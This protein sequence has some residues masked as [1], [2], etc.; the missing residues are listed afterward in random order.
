M[1]ARIHLEN[2]SLWVS[3]GKEEI[4]PKKEFSFLQT[5]QIWFANN[6]DKKM[7]D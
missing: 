2:L 5:P 4:L 3:Q 7:K 1:C 6:N